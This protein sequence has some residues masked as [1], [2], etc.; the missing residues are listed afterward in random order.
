M[1]V[2]VYQILEYNIILLTVE[3]TERKSCCTEEQIMG[4]AMVSESDFDNVT[5]DWNYKV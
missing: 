5:C 2:Y 3:K 4:I 1:S